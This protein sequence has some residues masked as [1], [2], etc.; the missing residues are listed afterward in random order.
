M[1]FKGKPISRRQF[2]ARSTQTAAGIFAASALTSCS[3]LQL[4]FTQKRGS[5]MNFGL[6]TYLWA[7]DWPLPTL[8]KNCETA[9]VF[10]VELR[11]THAHGVEPGLNAQQRKQVKKRFND[12]PLTLVGLGSNERFDHPD[13]AAL[14]KSIQVTKD[15][16]KLSY[17]VGGSGV[18][19]KPNSFRQGV[20]HEK[21]IE[22]IGTTLNTVAKFAA[23]YDQQVRLEV[24]GKCRYLP[25]IKAIMDF[26]DH[27]NAVVCWNSND[28]DLAGKGLE[29]NFNLVKD[30]FGATAHLRELDSPEYPYQKLINLFVDADYNGWILLEARTK[31]QDRVKGLAEQRELFEK[32]LQ[33]AQAR[34]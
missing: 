17:D 6:V 1:S 22:Q 13:P 30:R 10:G 5:K 2:F 12:S 18:K 4:P 16:I 31:R 21:T 9:K 11:T 34:S 20:P 24:H 27:P 32:M 14:A 7:H 25:T 26:A 8:I 3:S 33:K 29:Y 28:S 19:I 23:D 15:F